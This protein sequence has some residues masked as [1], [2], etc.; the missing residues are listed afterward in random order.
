MLAQPSRLG[1]GPRLV[2][3]NG[4]KLRLREPY[5]VPDGIR[6][7]EN[8]RRHRQTHRLSSDVL[9]GLSL[10]QVQ[11]AQCALRY[12]AVCRT[13]GR[14]KLSKPNESRVFF[15]MYMYMYKHLYLCVLHCVCFISDPFYLQFYLRQIDPAIAPGT[16]SAEPE[17]DDVWAPRR[18]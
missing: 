8:A 2:R 3:A 5:C 18:K 1:A 12:R 15:C 4:P 17:S 11:Q 16:Q 9:V 7:A 13:I 14:K 10:Q 6:Q